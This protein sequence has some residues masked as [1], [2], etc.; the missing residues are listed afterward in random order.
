[1]LRHHMM[2]APLLLVMVMQRLHIKDARLTHAPRKTSHTRVAKSQNA[3]SMIK[4]MTK[5]THMKAAQ[6][7]HAREKNT[8]RQM[9]KVRIA[10][11]MTQ[12]TVTGTKKPELS[13]LTS[14]RKDAL[15]H[16]RTVM[17]MISQNSA[18][19]APTQDLLSFW[20]SLLSVVSPVLSTASI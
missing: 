12:D 3:S 2:V 19:V 6:S 20:S 7:H 13:R 5:M 15:T 1:M 11:Q 8:S 17:M 14:Q 9:M 16:A 18:Q 10:F 4:I